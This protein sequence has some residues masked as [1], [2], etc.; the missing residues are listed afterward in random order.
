MRN[1][2][3]DKKIKSLVFTIFYKM[4]PKGKVILMVRVL[5]SYLGNCFLFTPNLG[6]K[7]GQIFK[8]YH[9]KKISSLGLMDKVRSTMP[10]SCEVFPYPS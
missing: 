6:W 4:H 5:L 10:I 8:M 9:L 3:T 7:I 1:N 2:I